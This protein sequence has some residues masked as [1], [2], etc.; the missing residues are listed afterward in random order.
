MEWLYSL[1]VWKSGNISLT[2]QK[3]GNNCAYFHGKLM[4][5]TVTTYRRFCKDMN[6]NGLEK[7]SNFEFLE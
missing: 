7:K 3:L 1:A 5:G 4:N 2:K 6:P